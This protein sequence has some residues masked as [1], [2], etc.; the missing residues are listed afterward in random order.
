MRSRL[1]GNGLNG[2]RCAKSEPRAA[3]PQIFMQSDSFV[4]LRTHTKQGTTITGK[5]AFYVASAW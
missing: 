1:M 5:S 2:P 3:A 4:G